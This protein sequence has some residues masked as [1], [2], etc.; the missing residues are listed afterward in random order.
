MASA[1]GLIPTGNSGGS[2]E[3]IEI[4]ADRLVATNA[5][6]WVDFTGSVK[7]KQG[8]FTLTADQLRIY[9]EGDLIS[10]SKTK[11]TRES[12]QKMVATGRVHIVAEPYVADTDR[13]EYELATDT[14]TL[15]GAN[16]KVVSGKN[17][18]TGSKIVLKRSEGKAEVVGSASERVKALFYS[19]PKG[20][21]PSDSK[22]PK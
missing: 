6:K 2:G 17:I 7:A 1:A 20:D 11:P 18:L 9:Y 12:I 4:V 21:Q 14:L 22:K 8:K 15:I 16:S 19:E 10:P 5:E 3:P 13:A